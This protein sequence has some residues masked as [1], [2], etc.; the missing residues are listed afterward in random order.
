MGSAVAGLGGW[1]VHAVPDISGNLIAAA[2]GGVL[3]W[4]ATNARRRLKLV[5]A[6]RFWRP[7]TTNRVIR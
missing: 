2:I 3:A 4:S 5:R 6:R 7:D 1:L